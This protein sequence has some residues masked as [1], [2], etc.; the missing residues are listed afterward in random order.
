M[1]QR[2]QIG[3]GSERE[4]A[5]VSAFSVGPRWEGNLQR[6][7]GSQQIILIIFND[8]LLNR[9]VWSDK[10]YRTGLNKSVYF[11]N[12]SPYNDERLTVAFRFFEIVHVARSLVVKE[13][14]F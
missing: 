2:I 14:P 13:I 6:I 1:I 9:I 10:S 5:Y 11:S 8:S 7:Q 12:P 3:C 4:R